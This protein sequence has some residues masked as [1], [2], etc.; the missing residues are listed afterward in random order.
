MG[1]LSLAVKRHNMVSVISRKKSQKIKLEDPL[2]SELQEGELEV[3]G[4]VCFL[5]A[6]PNPAI[7]S[8]NKYFSRKKKHIE[9]EVCDIVINHPSD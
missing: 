6:I 7:S 3:I 8:T 9:P 2:K 1:R 4:L 5:Y